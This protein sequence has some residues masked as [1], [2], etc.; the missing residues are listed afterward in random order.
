MGYYS[1]VSFEIP[2]KDVAGL[3]ALPPFKDDDQHIY[4]NVEY[5][6]GI[7]DIKT[8]KER[9]YGE[10]FETV[11]TVIFSWEDVKW[12]YDAAKAITDYV[13]SLDHYNFF[14]IGEEYDD[15]DIRNSGTMDE[16]NLEISRYITPY[17]DDI[18]LEDLRKELDEHS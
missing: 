15:V 17:G 8:G 3:L 4:D 13:E 1:C 6:L 7:A 2:K 14:R 11:D 9:T 12:Y 18:K 5:L 10:K 16:D